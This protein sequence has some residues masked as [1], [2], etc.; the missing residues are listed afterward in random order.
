MQIANAVMS[1]LLVLGIAAT[2]SAQAPAVRSISFEGAEWSTTDPEA[3]V[4]R[5]FGREAL[6]LR[7][8]EV[9][10]RDVQFTDGTIEFE[11]VARPVRSFLGL[12][13][14]VAEANGRLTYEDI[15]FRPSSS[16]DWDA[17]QYEPV[18]QGVGAWQLYHG[19]GYTAAVDIPT[20]R[21]THVR[22]SVAGDAA[23]VYLD[24]RETPVLRVNGLSGNDGPGHVG[25]WGF[26]PRG[27][28]KT[29][30]TANFANVRITPS[31]AAAPSLPSPGSPVPA[32]LIANWR[33]APPVPATH[34]APAGPR[35]SGRAIV[36][37][38]NGV[39]NLA[40]EF[41]RSV[42][43]PRMQTR[44]STAIESD[45]ARRVG[46]RVGFSDR[47][48]VLLNGDP[49]F[50]GVNEFKL[51]YPPSLGLVKLGDRVVYLPLR[52]GLNELTLEVVETEDFGWGFVAQLIDTEGITLR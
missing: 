14:R 19:K 45:R 38:P 46:L 15:Y 25:F 41:P 1:A 3:K 35:Q 36:A 9:W 33:V 23:E 40:R 48:R 13:F 44:A 37:D 5:L 34:P 18:F 32:G 8:G 49:L 24:R 12:M 27:E 31:T 28:P 10:R 52:P 21:W 51:G 29:L 30:F 43:G 20:N 6:L 17:I 4:E 22:V 7:T 50:E 39:V 2:A 11:M 16:G 47:L 26:F 42:D